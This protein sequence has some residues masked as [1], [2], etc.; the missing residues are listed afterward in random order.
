MKPS[1]KVKNNREISQSKGIKGMLKIVINNKSEENIDNEK[2]KDNPIK[3]LK[4]I[5]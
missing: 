1:E 5:N 3:N 2:G 4:T